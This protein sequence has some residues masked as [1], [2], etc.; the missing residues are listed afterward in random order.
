M[1]RALTQY[2]SVWLPG[3]EVP[4]ILCARGRSGVKPIEAED[5][6][7]VVKLCHLPFVE[8]LNGFLYYRFNIMAIVVDR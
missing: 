1:D 2:M 6:R 3:R 4:M 5:V 7:L 8:H